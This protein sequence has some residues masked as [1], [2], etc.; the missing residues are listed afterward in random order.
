M[1]N[2]T[3]TITED[4]PQTAVMCAIALGSN[5]GDRGAMLRDGLVAIAQLPNVWLQ[6]SSAWHATNAVTL[7]DA[8]PQ[9]EYLNAAAI[10][11]TTLTARQLLEALLAIELRYGR[12]RSAD[13]QRW[14]PRT[15]DLDL[16]LY[17]EQCYQEPGLH[18]PHPRMHEREFVLA[19]LAAIAPQMMVPSH[20]A[21]AKSVAVLHT[22]LVRSQKENR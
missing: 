10:V 12:D 6:A 22:E 17:G 14:G 11:R 21:A 13:A 7:A 2:T 5:M 4:M 20:G 16:L 18:V 8:Q 9:P 19:P 1:P 15:L 3:L